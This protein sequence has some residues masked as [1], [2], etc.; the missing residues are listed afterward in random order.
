VSRVLLVRHGQAN[1]GVGEYDELSPLGASQA[2]MLAEHLSETQIRFDSVFCGNLRRQSD[3]VDRMAEVYLID[4]KLPP[5]TTLS[6]LDEFDFQ[7]LLKEYATKL[8]DEVDRKKLIESRAYFQNFLGRAWNAWIAGDVEAAETWPA[9]QARCIEAL[10]SI[11]Q[12]CGRGKTILAVTSAGVICTILQSVMGISDAQTIRL[13]AVMANTSVTSLLYD[14]D[15]VSLE[16]FNQIPHLSSPKRQ[17]L[18]TYH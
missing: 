2:W 18:I 6:Q 12:N 17:D 13:S 3:T 11:R 1:F 5:A 4:G 10:E 9:F 8:G 14:D 7:P 15:R 16:T